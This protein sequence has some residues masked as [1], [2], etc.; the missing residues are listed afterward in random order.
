MYC[1]L[2]ALKWNVSLNLMRTMRVKNHHMDA[3]NRVDGVLIT[4]IKRTKVISVL[5]WEILRN[6]TIRHKKFTDPL[7]RNDKWSQL[8]NQ[9]K[10]FKFTFERFEVIRKAVSTF[11][12]DFKSSPLIMSWSLF[13]ETVF[14]W[15]LSKELLFAFI[16]QQPF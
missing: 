3:T 10:V 13:I 5:F 15:M 4:I 7:C 12:A 11:E 14:D 1:D 2:K 6:S 16:V 8:T 9:L